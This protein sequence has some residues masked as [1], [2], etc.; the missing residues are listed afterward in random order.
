[1]SF[2]EREASKDAETATANASDP[3][4]KWWD[5]TPK[6]EPEP[7]DQSDPYFHNGEDE[8]V[9]FMEYQYGYIN[10]PQVNLPQPR[11]R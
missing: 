10:L 2:T 3:P 8:S 4:F 5:V 11:P 1:M 7:L 9:N 6:T